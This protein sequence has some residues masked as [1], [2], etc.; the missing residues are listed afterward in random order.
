[1]CN[2]FIFAVVDNNCYLSI[3]INH[4]TS[5]S[6]S[7]VSVQGANINPTAYTWKAGEKTFTIQ[8]VGD[9]TNICESKCYAIK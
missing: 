7:V 4:G 8:M 2:L 3:Q 9:Y 5:Y 6:S 1:M